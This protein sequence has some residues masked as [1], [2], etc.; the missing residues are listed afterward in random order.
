MS[1]DE[2]LQQL[3]LLT[4]QKRIELLPLATET[5]A[6]PSYP[7]A[8][9]YVNELIGGTKPETAAEGL[10]VSLCK[11]V[12]DLTPTPQ[13]GLRDGWV[14]FL[15]NEKG[16]RPIAIEL[17]PLFR[18]GANE[19]LDRNDANPGH[20]KP[21]IKKYLAEHE[22]IVFTDLRTAW[23]CSTR[24]YFFE[25]KPFATLPFADFLDQ[26]REARSLT[27]ALRRLEDRTDKPNL[28]IQ[29]FGDL[30]NWFGEFEKVHWQPAERSA[31]FIIL[32]LNK[33]IFAK[34]LEDFG[35]VPYRFIQDEY[36]LRKDRWE[37]KGAAK[38]VRHFLS[39]FEDF[40]DEY[41][42][43]EIF[44]ERIADKLA[45]EEANYER[46]CQKLEFVLGLDPW[47]TAM[48]RGVVNY[49]YRR[50]DE[51]IFGKSYEMFLAADRK[52]EGIY[53]TPAGIT[54]P[55]ADS[56]VDTLAGSLVDQVCTAVDA[57]V[58]DFA[59][60]DALL[61]EL[62]EIR[63]ADTACGSGGFLIKVLRAFWRQ[64]QRVD[65]ATGW[66]TRLLKPGNGSLQ[67]DELPPNVQQAQSFRQRHGFDQR[68]T[69]IA[70]LLLW[71]IHGADKDAGALEVAKTNIWKEAVKLSA[72]DYNYRD[73][74]GD[75][76]KILPNL[77]LNFL[78]GDSLVDVDLAKQVAWLGEY[79][80][81][82]LKKLHALRTRYISNPMNHGPLDE[83]LALRRKLNEGLR[84]QFQSENL[85][86]EP[87]GYALHF[88][89]CWFSADGTKRSAGGFDGILGNPPWEGFKPLRKEFV[90]KSRA[91]FS[92][93]T[94]AGPDFTPWF[95]QE[96]KGNTDFRKRW[97]SYVAGYE[98]FSEYF[99]R[100]FRHQGGGDYNLFKLFIESNL[101]LVREAG[102]LSML[103]PSGF[104][105]DEGCGDLRR[106]L[107][108]ENTLTE[109]T[110]F[111]NRGY[112]DIEDGK[113][114]RR[115]IFPDVHPQFK[116]GF[117]KVVK[118]VPLRTNVEFAGR[119]YLHDPKQVHGP[120]IRYCADMIRRFSPE[121]FGIME[122]RSEADYVL[123]A[124]IRGEHPLLKDTGCR[125]AS[126]LHMTNDSHFFRKL[127]GKKAVSGQ[128]ALFEGK[129]IHQ[130]D[131]KYS[132]GNYALDEKLIREELL[133]RETHRLV[134]LVRQAGAAKFEGKE[135]PETREAL[136]ARVREVFTAKGFKLHF[137][138]PRVAYREIGRSTDERTIIA[139]EIP[140]GAC[141]NNKLP[142]L[143]PLEWELTS[144][145]VLRQVAP[146]RLTPKAAL[147][148]L[149][150]LVLNYYLRSKISATLNMFYMYELPFPNL[151]GPQTKKLT[152]MADK[153]LANPRD[154]AE[155][156]ALEVLIARDL[157][158][159]SRADWEHLTSTFTF[160]S[161][162]SKAELDE[163]IRQ[164]KEAW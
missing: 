105:T 63:V 128:V 5:V 30:K 161:G 112:D 164:S 57:K 116:F 121:N 152:A 88:W 22:Y 2:I 17:K 32:L 100:R 151:T 48:G 139:T 101:T 95:E 114:L 90:A 10:F 49:N 84:E 62:A 52:D 104:Q 7:P 76:V 1:P 26:C 85:P 83:A 65:A 97:E 156:A 113:Q 46:F 38:V 120:A 68:R 58:C 135:V 20:H 16:Q 122:F 150:S 153:L 98:V 94:I 35:L 137:E 148:L 136:E 141:L 146:V 25:E 33:L 54:T 69:L 67:L 162:E 131:A 142:Y 138:C 125:L 132:P 71:H 149:N 50:I 124:K 28:E 159:L 118:E 130:F 40:F 80:Q 158:G 81:T 75:T 6:L 11:D 61:A 39:E 4:E 134:R 110:S 155:R 126:E 143:V 41:Y 56:L 102:S 99:G 45:P 15:V 64:Y 96:L 160:G 73:L 51:D 79:H 119:F 103:I 53:Y 47:N 27:D 23:L 92:K 21:Q 127:S 87:A 24:D 91:N 93:S 29:F 144:K 55:M 70:R 117:F 18:R 9:R 36:E 8:R 74:K 66:V 145:G 86:T 43:T 14:D 77:E 37:A 44:A 31:E 123:S 72:S 12:L 154:V 129:M 108:T 19:V 106:L 60:A 147:G 109:L 78:C 107:L 59:R 13:V 157:Y 163:I 140:P 111:E 34:T 133:R 3:R 82:E 89:P 42:D 115:K